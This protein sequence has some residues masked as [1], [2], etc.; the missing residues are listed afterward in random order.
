MATDAPVLKH[1]A[2]GIHG[3]DTITIAM[4]KADRE[5]LQL[6]RLMVENNYVL[7][8]D[9]LVILFKGKAVTPKFWKDTEEACLYVVSTNRTYRPTSGVQ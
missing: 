5:I 9:N 6:W 2:V 3:V 7:K 8:K 4:N 1:L